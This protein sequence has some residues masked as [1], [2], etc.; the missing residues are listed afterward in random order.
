MHEY[1]CVLC[2][3][4][5]L[6]CHWTHNH[7]V[8]SA[9]F[10]EKFLLWTFLK[11]SWHFHTFQCKLSQT[12][13]IGCALTQNRYAG[14]AG[15]KITLNCMYLLNVSVVA[16]GI[17][18][19]QFCSIKCLDMAFFGNYILSLFFTLKQQ[20]PFGSKHI[21]FLCVREPGYWKVYENEL[22][23]KEVQNNAPN[24]KIHILDHIWIS[25]FWW[26]ETHLRWQN[27]IGGKGRKY[28]TRLSPHCYTAYYLDHKIV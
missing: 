5:F 19:L 6:Y 13:E 8:L 3:I 27:E 10:L 2:S 12:T 18:C 17:Q 25:V 23:F 28:L 9:L 7:S 15:R 21:Q 11:K 22:F 16:A 4:T 20:F 26:Q 1:I 24:L 14:A